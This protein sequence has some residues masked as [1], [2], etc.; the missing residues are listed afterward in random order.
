MSTEGHSKDHLSVMAEKDLP[1]GLVDGVAR[2]VGGLDLV[3][4]N[5]YE[6]HH[7]SEDPIKT[8]P[9]ERLPS[10]ASILAD[11]ID[12][13]WSGSGELHY[14]LPHD[15]TKADEN[16]SFSLLSESTHLMLY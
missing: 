16:R 1:I 15:L 5:I 7:L 12:M 11:K 3:F 6:G 10:L 8:D 14:N 2:D 13:A 9:V 4:S